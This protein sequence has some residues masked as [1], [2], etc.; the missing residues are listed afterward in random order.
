[1]PLLYDGTGLRKASRCT[2]AVAGGVNVLLASVVIAAANP[3]RLGLIIFNNSSNSVYVTFG[4]TSSSATCT[5]LI[6]TFASWECIGAVIYTGAV[7]AIRNAGSGA[8]IAYELL[9]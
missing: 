4:G 6:P 2:P 1:M 8:C 5:R 3:D 7:S 9:S